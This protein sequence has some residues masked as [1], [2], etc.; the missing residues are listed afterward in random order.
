MTKSGYLSIVGWPNAGKST[1]MNKLLGH[2]L[3]IISAKPQT[4]RGVIT[5]ILNEP[6]LQMIMLDTPGWIEPRDL[7]QA[8]MKKFILRSI[9]EDADINLWVVDGSAW[10]K[11]ELEW[12]DLLVKTGKPL[13]VAINKIDN[14]SLEAVA[15]PIRAQIRERAGSPDLAVFSVSALN[16]MGFKELKQALIN[17]L[18]EGPPYYP[19]DQVTNRFER[20]HVTELI[21][22]TL[23]R[24]FHDEVPHASAVVLEEFREKSGQKDVISASIFVETEGQ[25]K[26]VIGHQGAKIKQV[27]TEARKEIEANLNRPVFLELRVKVKKNWRQDAQFV[28]SLLSADN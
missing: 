10:T 4:T 15:E 22:E 26:I 18:P 21:R 20:Y 14:S 11:E 16:R 1:L 6:D 19:T 2:K 8:S 25:K 12:V 7:L 28:A 13:V 17:L 23:M 3:S 24:L 5:G 9:Y 27:G